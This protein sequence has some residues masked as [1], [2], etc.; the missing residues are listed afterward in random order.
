MTK[1]AIEA[2]KGEWI[3][4]G[5]KEGDDVILVARLLRKPVVFGSMYLVE[6]L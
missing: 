3:Q 1:R 5:W 6:G 2:V 4:K